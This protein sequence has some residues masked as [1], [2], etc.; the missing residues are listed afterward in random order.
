MPLAWDIPP[1]VYQRALKASFGFVLNRIKFSD[2]KATEVAVR[3]T[4]CAQTKGRE[5]TSLL[6]LPSGL[7]KTSLWGQGIQFI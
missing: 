1:C 2:S 7:S 4:V 3:P 6:C 5:M